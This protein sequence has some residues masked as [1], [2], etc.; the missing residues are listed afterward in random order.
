MAEYIGGV[1]KFLDGNGGGDLL[2]QYDRVSRVLDWFP[3]GNDLEAIYSVLRDLSV[4]GSTLDPAAAFVLSSVGSVDIAQVLDLFRGINRPG[5]SRLLSLL[6]EYIFKS[7]TI[8]DDSLLLRT[9]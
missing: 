5:F 7:C 3:E 8:E 1:R 9:Y 6:Q 2:A 4:A